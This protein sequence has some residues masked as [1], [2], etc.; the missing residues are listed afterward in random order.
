[1]RLLIAEDDQ[2]LG[3]GL[4]QVLRGAGYVVDWARDG[5]DADAALTQLEYDAVILDLGL[6]RMDGLEVL[7]RLRARGM[8]IPVMILTARDSVA[9]KVSGLDVGADDYLVKPFDVAE[10]E[11]RVRALVRRGK[12]GAGAVIELGDVRFDTAGKRVFVGEA[13]V[14]LTAREYGVFEILAL[15]AGRVVNKEQIVARLCD[16]G[17]EVNAG[18]IEVYVHRLRKKLEHGTVTIRTIR[19]LG[20]LLEAPARGA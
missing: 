13:P 14:D 5:V 4:T 2:V 17:E 18:A 16:Q 20:Y 6:P 8:N 12:G 19:G 1:M 11:A 3:D 7:R 10:L 9:D 15:N